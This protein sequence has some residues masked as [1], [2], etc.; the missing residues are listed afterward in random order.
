MGCWLRCALTTLLLLAPAAPAGASD[1]SPVGD[2]DAIAN[3]FSVSMTLAEGAHGLEPK[4]EGD[5]YEDEAVR[6]NH[7]LK[8]YVHRSESAVGTGPF[9]KRSVQFKRYERR[10]LEALTS[11]PANPVRLLLVRSLA[12]DSKQCEA[13]I[14]G[15]EATPKPNARSGG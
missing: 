3:C 8:P 10:L 1:F 13:M 14:D 9:F 6:L 11:Q 12:G 4:A 7:R 15:W 2:S 5:L